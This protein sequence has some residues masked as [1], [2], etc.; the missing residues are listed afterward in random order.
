MADQEHR[1]DRS[2]AEDRPQTLEQAHMWLDVRKPAPGAPMA[3]EQ[4]FRNLCAD[5]YWRVAETDP[6]N[7]DLARQWAIAERQMA[8]RLGAQIAVRKALVSYLGPDF[9]TPG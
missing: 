2:S 3:E 5:I 4:R 6:G 8:G 1:P 9:D 7:K